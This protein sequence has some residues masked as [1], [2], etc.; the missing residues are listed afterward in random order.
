MADYLGT[1]TICVIDRG[2]YMELAVRLAR[3]F[4]RVLLFNPLWKTNY[5]QI[6]DAT[7]GEGLENV[8]RI[9]DFYDYI[10]EID[11]FV[12][13]D[14]LDGDLQVFLREK[15]GKRVFGSGKCEEI[16][17]CRMETKDYLKSL[18]LPIIPAIELTG[19]T[20]LKEH[21]KKVKNKYI[22]IDYFRGFFETFHHVEW[23]DTEPWFDEKVYL[24]G[25]V[26]ESVN[27]IVEDAIDGDDVVEL[28]FD[29][30]SI[31]GQYPKKVPL[32]YEIKDVGWICKV[33][34][35]KDLHPAIL[36]FNEK[37]SETLKI[38]SYRNFFSPEIRVGKNGIGYMNDA[39]CRFPSPVSEAYYE[40]ITNFSEIIWNGGEG[41][42]VEPEYASSFAMT[43]VICSDWAKDHWQEVRFPKEI[44]KWVKLR[45]YTI[46]DG[47][48]YVVPNMI[49]KNDA[50]GVVVSIGNS[51]ED[52]AKKINEYADQIHGY[53]ILIEC[54]VL[55]KMKKVIEKG[56]AI[57]AK[58]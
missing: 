40:L 23:V 11:E 13:P 43:L 16:E 57:G 54:A 14:V 44:R 26:K 32:G 17:L 3:D 1:K 37:I 29:G 2:S 22:K 19:A 41:I 8:E 30:F 35:Y 53:K 5:P 18:G 38:N 27:F 25:P 9:D 46:I 33:K 58:F 24:L 15:L 6:V 7:I 20:K 47:I 39:C 42:M 49:D 51:L 55:E 10:D 31:D 56:E 21:L 50:V 34:N 4:K 52:C 48:Y 28:A 12:F 45:N 36:D